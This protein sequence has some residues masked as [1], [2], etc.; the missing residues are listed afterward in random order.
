MAI[1]REK[2]IEKLV[3]DDIDSILCSYNNMGD[4]S[5]LAFILESGFKGYRNY[6]DQQLIREVLERDL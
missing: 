5:T 4:L 6:D 3:D 2:I 1:D